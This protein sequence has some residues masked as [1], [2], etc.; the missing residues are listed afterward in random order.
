MTHP[1]IAIIFAANER[2]RLLVERLEDRMAISEQR[3]LEL[4]A[5]EYNAM[6]EPEDQVEGD[7]LE[8]THSWPCTEKK[9]PIPVCVYDSLNDPAFDDCIFCHQPHERK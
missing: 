5:A 1:D 4:V 9:N 8:V 7:C 3:M 2:K 6:V